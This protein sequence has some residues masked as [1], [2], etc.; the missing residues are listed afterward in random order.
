MCLEKLCVPSGCETILKYVSRYARLS[1]VEIK[2]RF[3]QL[4]L[5]FY[6]AWSHMKVSKWRRFRDSHSVT[7]TIAKMKWQSTDSTHRL[8]VW[9]FLPIL[10]SFC[11]FLCPLVIHEQTGFR[12]SA[13]EENVALSLLLLLI[14]CVVLQLILKLQC[15][16]H[17]PA[18][19]VTR[20]NMVSEGYYSYAKLLPSMTAIKHAK[21]DNDNPDLDVNE[22]VSFNQWSLVCVVV[23]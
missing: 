11:G 3:V 14:E 4:Y 22:L 15:G 7:I 6:S 8:N 13:M 19:F 10:W 23:Q 1:W 17:P 20:E 5:I 12:T 18:L 16:W 9:C 21:I 2:G